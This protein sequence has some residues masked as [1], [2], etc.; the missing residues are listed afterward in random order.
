MDHVL[1]DKIRSPIGLTSKDLNENFLTEK[2]A[3]KLSARVIFS[4]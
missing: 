4:K 3:Q 1:I 2:T